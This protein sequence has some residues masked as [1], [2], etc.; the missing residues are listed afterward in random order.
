MKLQRPSLR[1]CQ[2]GSIDEHQAYVCS[3]LA[4]IAVAGGSINIIFTACRGKRYSWKREGKHTRQQT[5]VSKNLIAYSY[6]I[7]IVLWIFQKQ[8]LAI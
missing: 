7:L 4:S 1:S 6:T 3:Q 8:N 2:Y 5:I